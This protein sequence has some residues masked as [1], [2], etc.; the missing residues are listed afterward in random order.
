MTINGTG[1]M[2]KTALAATFAERFAWRWRQGV[3]AFSFA[4]AV[5]ASAFRAALL[6]HLLGAQA[7]QQLADADAPTQVTEILRAARDWDGLLVLDN[8]ES[9]L[10]E[11]NTPVIASRFT[12]KQ[13][14]SCGREMASRIA[15]AM[16]V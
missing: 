3:R 12:A 13:S 9:V 6:R 8:Y 14:P 1:G 15:P 2:G 16:T 10:Q 4:S 11:L 5:D 7:A